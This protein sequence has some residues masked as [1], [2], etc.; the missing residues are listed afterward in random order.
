MSIVSGQDPILIEYKQ[1]TGK[2]TIV[3]NNYHY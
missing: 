1:S 2:Q 3:N